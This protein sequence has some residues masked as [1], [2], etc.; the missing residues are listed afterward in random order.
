MATTRMDLD[1]EIKTFYKVNK[2]LGDS[3]VAQS[4]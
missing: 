2:F 3:K 4:E 1:L